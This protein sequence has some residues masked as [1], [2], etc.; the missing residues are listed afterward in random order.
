MLVVIGTRWLSTDAAGLRINDA[1]DGVRFE[2][3]TAFQQG[4]TVIPVL[5]DDGRMPQSREL[6]TEVRRLTRIQAQ[7]MRGEAWSYH[8][9]KLIDALERSGM[10]P[11]ATPAL[12]SHNGG[13][14]P[15]LASPRYTV[16]SEFI[17]SRQRVLQA[18]VTSL[19]GMD[20]PI[21]DVDEA[22]G[23]VKLG[24][25]SK[26]PQPLAAA[27]KRIVRSVDEPIVARV[28]DGEPGRGTIELS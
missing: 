28:R 13:A 12:N 26:L 21:R 7:R 10:R 16:E 17:G 9:S 8:L 27:L 19:E 23:V 20:V 18:L 24:S 22:A 5:I 4:I 1:T 2:V 25:E 14:R 3:S 6:P 15:K 11:A